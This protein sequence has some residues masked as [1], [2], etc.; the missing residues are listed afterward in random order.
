MIKKIY[1]AFKEKTFV[2]KISNKLKNVFYKPLLKKII[3]NTKINDKKIIFL[4]FQKKYTCNQKA[5]CE[6]ILHNHP[7]YEVVW[8]TTLNIKEEIKNYPANIKL[9]K[10]RSLKFYKELASSKFIIQNANETIYCGYNKKIGQIIIQTWHGSLG[11]K[12]LETFNNKN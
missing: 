6:E 2:D 4:T 12:R 5:I 7:D 3:N 9:V 10:Y 1:R 11:F 8:G